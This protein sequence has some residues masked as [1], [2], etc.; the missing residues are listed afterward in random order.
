MTPDA[1]NLLSQEARALLTRLALVKPLV[2]QETMVP[3]ANVS[4]TASAGMER[5]LGS[6]RRTVRALVRSFLGWLR[7]EGGERASD[8]QAQRRFSLVR[9][10][11]NI[12]LS[13]FDIFAD[14]YS[15][16]SE[17]DVGVWLAGLDVAAA[18]AL[19]LPRY[20]RSPPLVCYLDRGIGAAI[21]RARTR[22]PGGTPSP[23]GIVRIPRERMVG[24]GIASSLM[25]EV[26]H[27]GAALLD[28]VSSLRGTL[29]GLQRGGA[30]AE[31]WRL[32]DRWISEIIADFWSV[33][34][35]GI[36]STLGL[37]GVVSLPP[38][39]VFRVNLA[40]PHPMPWIRVRLSCAIGAALFPHAQ[41]QRLSELWRSLY[42]VD[43]L[44]AS[45]RELIA[46][47]EDN[48]PAFAEMLAG[49]RPSSL[50]GASLREALEVDTR[51]PARL[52]QLFR[53]AQHRPGGLKRLPPSLAF[54]VL[55]QAR[56][57]GELSPEGEAAQVSKLLRQW[58]LADTLRSAESCAAADHAVHHQYQA[59]RELAPAT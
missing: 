46:R 10:Q 45:R 43:G 6:G 54:A 39:F 34:R 7:G 59:R 31:V 51:Q 27:Q 28:L 17:Q 29:R 40:D 35:V 23:V 13:Q 24:S 50:R 4:D 11:F 30:D 20:Y 25:H 26:G 42:P 44:D 5:A 52:V 57:N 41:W 37:M 58:A 8:A 22:L 49:H 53:D 9:M 38:P 33:A 3:A 36:T 15:Q 21:R 16:R 56:A 14:A 32:W 18:D 19:A 48:M 12:M 47:L 1:R 2:L 55:G